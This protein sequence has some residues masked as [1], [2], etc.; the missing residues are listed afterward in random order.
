MVVTVTHLSLGTHTGT[1]I[2]APFHFFPSGKKLHEIELDRFVGRAVVLDVR[3]LAKERAMIDW[4]ALSSSTT[5]AS[6]LSQ[7]GSRAEGKADI[8]LLWTGWEVHW[9]TPKYFA[10]PYFSRE[11]AGKLRD[12]GARIVGVD[13]LSPDETPVDENTET[14]HGWGVHEVLLGSG[15]LICENLR[16]VGDLVDVGGSEGE[17]VWVSLMPLSIHG[18]DGAPVRAYGWKTN[19]AAR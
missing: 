17:E 11:V 9:G 5:I 13:V 15:V 1:H 19:P 14:N 2:D 8:V 10:H 18:A 12:H 7:V 3:H 4:V 6:G 16:G